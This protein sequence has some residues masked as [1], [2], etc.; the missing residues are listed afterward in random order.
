MKDNFL[1]YRADMNYEKALRYQG[2]LSSEGYR[3]LLAFT[4]N[5]TITLGIASKAKNEILISSDSL[6][7]KNIQLLKTDRG[8]KSTY[9]GPGQLIGFPIINLRKA[10]KDGRAVR[11]FSEDL[12]IGLAHAGA[13][14]GVKSVQTKQGF[15]GVWTNRGKLASIGITVK[16][17]F[18]FHGFSLNVTRA[19]Y[20]GF[21][22]IDP[23]GISNCPVT[24]LEEEGITV[25]SKS[26]LARL[27]SPYLSNLFS[28]SKE[29]ESQVMRFEQTHQDLVAKVSRSSMAIDY[30]CSSLST[31]D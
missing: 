7:E 13:A 31:R 8:G 1:E 17:G 2:V 4:C 27:I 24:S 28:A 25:E 5:P 16:N 6:Q 19:C 26:E 18:I 10:Y 20:T 11:R 29:R 15:P 9:H 22:L 30:V 14:L 21:S 3:G 23:C 12:L